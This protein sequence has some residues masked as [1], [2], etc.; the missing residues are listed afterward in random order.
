VLAERTW[1]H[2]AR[3]VIEVASALAGAR[4]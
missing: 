2:N 1:E 4:A 3:R